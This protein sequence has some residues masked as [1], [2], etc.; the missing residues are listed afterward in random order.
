MKDLMNHSTIRENSKR[1]L[2]SE[3]GKAGDIIDR[4]LVSPNH[5]KLGFITLHD[6]KSKYRIFA[7][8]NRSDLTPFTLRLSLICK[9]E[10]W[11]IS[12]GDGFECIVYGTFK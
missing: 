8:I 1:K 4:I 11:K 5:K 3:N 7:G 6:G 12:T 9:D 2:V 10:P